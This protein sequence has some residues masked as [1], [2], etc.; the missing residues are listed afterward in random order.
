MNTFKQLF[1]ILSIIACSHLQA[2]HNFDLINANPENPIYVQANG[3]IWQVLNKEHYR[4]PINVPENNLLIMSLSANKDKSAAITIL[5][6]PEK[7]RDAAQL[8]GIKTTGTPTFYV[9]ATVIT[10]KDPS[11]AKTINQIKMTPQKGIGDSKQTKSGLSLE[12]NVTQG[13]ID[14]IVSITKQEKAGPAEPESTTATM[15]VEPTQE[16]MATEAPQPKQ[17][18]VSQEK[19][20]TQDVPVK[21]KRRSAKKHFTNQKSIV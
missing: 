7:V 17:E 21:R 3:G 4:Y 5:F 16:Q 8:T 20:V 1:T 13:M 10:E 19:K 15:T 18:L 2:A 9:E 11:S 6:S 12:H 14:A